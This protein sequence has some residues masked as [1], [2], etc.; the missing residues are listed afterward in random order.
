MLKVMDFCPLPKTWVKVYY[1][2]GQKRLD[3]AEKSAMYQKEKFKK[4]QKQ[5]VI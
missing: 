4:Q 2:C 3:S 1:K 5:V